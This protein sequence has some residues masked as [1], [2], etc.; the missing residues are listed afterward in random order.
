MKT[1]LGYYKKKL[2]ELFAMPYFIAFLFV[3]KIMVYYALIDVN[4]LEIVM[5]IVSLIVWSAIFICFSRSELKRKRG[6]FLLVYFLFSLLMFY[7]L[8]IRRLLCRKRCY[9]SGIEGPN[10]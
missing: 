9:L 4:K 7:D 2:K 1:V 3:F 6:I 5:I 8:F 10:I